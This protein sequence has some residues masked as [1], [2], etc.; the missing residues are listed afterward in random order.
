M[1]ASAPLLQGV[2]KAVRVSVIAMG[3]APLAPKDPEPESDPGPLKDEKVR[4]SEQQTCVHAVPAPGDKP[5]AFSLRFHGPATILLA[6]NLHSGWCSDQRP[7]PMC[8]QKPMHQP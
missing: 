8:T 3:A 6:S 1:S 4:H 7:T 5:H 2:K